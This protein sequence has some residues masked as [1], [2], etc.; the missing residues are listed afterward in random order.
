MRTPFPYICVADGRASRRS[1]VSRSILTETA[2]S[3]KRRRAGA[4]ISQFWGLPLGR[5]LWRVDI[6]LKWTIAS[7]PSPLSNPV[8]PAKAEIR[9]ASAKSA[10]RNHAQIARDKSLPPLW[11]KAR[12]G[13]SPRASAALRAGDSPFQTNV[14]HALAQPAAGARLGASDFTAMEKPAR[15]LKP[16]KGYS[17]TRAVVGID[18][19]DA[20]RRNPARACASNALRPSSGWIKRL[21]NPAQYF[22]SIR[23]RL[24]GISGYGEKRKLGES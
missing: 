16:A 17:L 20:G 3:R 7:P 6:G 21:F 22:I 12:M 18:R 14:N 11:G 15:Q 5:A 8:I 2:A 1:R 19:V 10:A 4:L 23:I 24:D 9:T 13:V